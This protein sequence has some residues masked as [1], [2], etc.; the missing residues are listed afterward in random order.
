MAAKNSELAQE[1]DAA[2][3]REQ[4]A[5]KRA[6]AQNMT[7]GAV[8]NAVLAH[9]LGA[10][11]PDL[12]VLTLARLGIEQAQAVGKG[13]VGQLER[14]LLSQATSLQAM[15]VYLAVK[16]KDADHRE[17]QHH[18]ITLGLKCAAQSRQAI[19]A[20]AE[21]RQPRSVMFAKQANLA[22]GPQQVNNGPVVNPTRVRAE[23]PPD[24]QNELLEMGNEQR[25][26]ARAAGAAG[27]NGAHMEALDP[28]HRPKERRRKGP[29]GQ[30]R[31]QRRSTREVPGDESVDPRPASRL[32][33]GA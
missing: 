30:Q 5:R 8:N 4:R 27:R 26:D 23:D 33:R 22:A 7:D 10:A 6:T 25:L 28:V 1:A 24:Q 2:S 14:M 18:Y 16:G 3:D 29:V 15:Y 12:D 17:W 20:L 11:T 31:I 19:V 21:L 32:P 9:Y 13:D